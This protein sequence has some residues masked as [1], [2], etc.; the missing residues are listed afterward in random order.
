MKDACR[1]LHLNLIKHLT[2]I[3][4][5]VLTIPLQ[6]VEW[7]EDHVKYQEDTVNQI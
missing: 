6:E 4:P 3:K 2:L 7:E 1:E 5:V